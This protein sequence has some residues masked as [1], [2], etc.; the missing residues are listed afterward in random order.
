MFNFDIQKARQMHEEGTSEDLHGGLQ[1]GLLKAAVYGANDGIIT[2]FA[3]V[4]GVAGAGLSP[5]V[6]VILGIAN[7]IADGLS[8]GIGD[9]LGERSEMKRL[10]HQYE[11][12]KWEIENIPDLEQKEL[13]EQ[14]QS[15]DVTK[16][17]RTKLKKL[18]TK[19]PKL[20]T[21]LGYV[22]EMGVIP[23][24]EGGLWKSGVMTFVAFVM[25]GVVPLLPYIVTYLGI[26]LE[27][28][29]QFP[30]S[31]VFTGVILFFV[32]IIRTRFT[33]GNWFINGIEMLGIGSL[34]AF[35]AYFL[36]AM[37]ERWVM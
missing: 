31:I 3:V 36:G 16:T 10:K 4:A 35:A 14:L 21:Y 29:Q 9:Y 22:E 28:N 15:F 13:D 5:V 24:F 20:W 25:A 23:E 11:V 8:M 7:M 33:K 34:A 27:S 6:I 18:I 19:Y 1:Q 17:D 12:E 26:P 37:V 2:T 32:G 30:L